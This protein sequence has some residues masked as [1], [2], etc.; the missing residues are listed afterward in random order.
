MRAAL[1]VV[2]VVA[3]AGVVSC[4]TATPGPGGTPGPGASVSTSQPA[5]RQESVSPSASGGGH[6]PS[7]LDD[8]A[9][10]FAAAQA[11]DQRLSAA[12]AVVDRHIG[13]TMLTVDP[14]VRDAAAAA[15]PGV[16]ARA[17]PA[18]LPPDLL[19]PVLLVYSDLFSRYSALDGFVNTLADTGPRVDVPVTDP[20]AAEALDC[21]HHGAPAAAQ[22]AAD[23]AAAR[24]EAAQSPP[25]VPAAKGSRAAADLAILLRY[26]QGWN[27]CCGG[28]G[29]WRLTS[30]PAITWYPSRAPVGG[31]Y[32]DLADG[33]IG[34]GP[35]FLATYTSGTGWTV[36]LYAG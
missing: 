26:V 22:F 16:A 13:T 23:M 20:A 4:G 30:L 35:E 3:L 14:S 36:V 28:C 18:G 15:D 24:A 6:A 2:M 25:V 9:P 34:D 27:T 11:V 5:S 21:L 32:G 10:F 7:A 31:S 12:A 29:G 8:L 19:Q 1:G 33:I 17:V